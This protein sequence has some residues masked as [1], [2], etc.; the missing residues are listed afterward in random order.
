MADARNKP[1]ARILEV[2]SPAAGAEISITPNTAAGWLFLSL[3]FQLVTSV[4][5]ATRVVTLS[6]T[7]QVRE[8]YRSLASA[9][10]I[11]GLTRVYGG[12]PGAS[13]GSAD[14]G[15]I[16][17]DMPV[18]GLWLPIG[19]TLRTITDLIDVADQYSGI[20]ASIIEFPGGPRETIWPFMPTLTEEAS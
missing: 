15:V 19:H 5:A 8:Y 17:L 14:D 7:N 16:T 4:A 13:R 3:R 6:M 12:F 20:A 18:Q 1:I 9:S 11:T 10:Q 2:E